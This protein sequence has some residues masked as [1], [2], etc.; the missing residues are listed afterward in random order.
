MRLRPTIVAWTA[1]GCEPIATTWDTGAAGGPDD[2]VGLVVSPAAID[3]GSVS[4]NGQGQALQSFRIANVGTWPVAVHGHDEPVMLAGG[5]GVFRVEAE[6]YFELEAGEERWFDA[7]FQ[8]NTEGDWQAELRVNYGLETLVLRGQGAAPVLEATD[9]ELPAQPFGCAVD[10]TALLQNTGSETLVISAGTLL[11]DR[12]WQVGPLAGARIAPGEELAVPLRFAPSWTGT[13]GGARDTFLRIDSNDP[14]VPRRD[15]PLRSLAYEGEQVVDLFDYAPGNRTDL[16]IV[17]ETDGVMAL[18]VDKAQAALDRLL[19]DLDLGNV[20]HHAAAL[21]PGSACP[22][23][24]PA[25]VSSTTSRYT[26]ARALD[27]A[28]DGGT[29]PMGDR[30]LRFAADALQ[31][32]A[33]GCLS[34]FLREGAQLHIVVIAGEADASGFSAATL[35]GDLQEAAPLAGSLAVSAI[36]A[37]DSAGC[38]GASYGA[39]YAE[40]ALETRGEILDLCLADWGPGFGRLADVSVLAG[41]GGMTRA[42]AQVPLVESIRV[43]VDGLTFDGWTWDPSLNAVRFAESGAPDAGSAVELRYMTAVSCP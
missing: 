42:L 28:L 13:P 33:S 37:T 29:G 12:D 30:L 27:A 23:S 41:R 26:R 36:I 11:D 14:L 43:K 9:T 22:I 15:L 39:G 21:T 7:R 2:Q 18:H 32:G 6:P 34:G 31:S 5:A 24:S 20:D 10:G 17:A 16:L 35:L 8:P 25:W 19:T 1:L 38:G 40:V 4:V 3:F